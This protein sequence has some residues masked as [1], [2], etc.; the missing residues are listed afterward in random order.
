[1]PANGPDWDAVAEAQYRWANTLATEYQ[2]DL[3]S[4]HIEPKVAKVS[5]RFNEDWTQRSKCVI[6]QKSEVEWYLSRALSAT[7][8]PSAS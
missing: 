2:A 6:M 4:V 8:S 1:M 3:E 7:R 5:Y